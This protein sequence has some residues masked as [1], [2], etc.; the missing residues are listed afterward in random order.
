M[1]ELTEDEK[2]KVIEGLT[3]DE[4]NNI[5]KY[6][7]KNFLAKELINNEELTED[8]KNKIIEYI[9]RYNLGAQTN[10]DFV[11]FCKQLLL[12]NYQ[13]QNIYKFCN[14]FIKRS[15]ICDK[16]FNIHEFEKSAKIDDEIKCIKHYIIYT[17]NN[18]GNFPEIKKNTNYCIQ[19]NKDGTSNIEHLL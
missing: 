4:K 7:D 9:T 8:E 17:L 2:N 5:I 6:Y 18:S 11:L 13:I 3:E 10:E 14:V 1:E 16:L 19:L 15:N 12:L